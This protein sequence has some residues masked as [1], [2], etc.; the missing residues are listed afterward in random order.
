MKRTTTEHHIEES[1]D[2]A[3]FVGVK[4]TFKIWLKSL[5]LMLAFLLSAHTALFAQAFVFSGGIDNEGGTRESG[6]TVTAKG[7]AGQSVT[8]NASGRYK[9]QLEYGKRHTIEVTKSGYA[10]RFF[11]V[12]LTNVREQDLSS[13]EDFASL[14]FVMVQEAPGVDLSALSSTPITTFTFQ[15][16]AGQLVKDDKQEAASNKAVEDAKAKKSSPNQNTDAANKEN[17]NKLKE[18]IKVG[19]QAFAAGDFEKAV[20]AFEDAIDFAGKNKLDESE[21]LSKL[22][23]ADAELKKK[24]LGELE[25]RQ[26]NEALFKLIDEGKKLELKK[27]FK[28]AKAKY[29]EA[30]NKKPGYK[31]AVDLLEKVNKILAEQEAEEKKNADYQKVIAEAKALFDAE[32]WKESK[33]KYQEAKT[34][35]ATEKEPDAQILIIDKKIAE[36]EKN[37]AALAKYEGI[38]A[39]ALA[40][41]NAEKY[42][43]AIAKYKEAQLAMKDRNEP[44]EGLAFCEQKKKEKADL[45]KAKADQE[46]LDKDYTAAV[47]KADGLYDGKKYAEAIKEYEIANKLK[48]DEAHPVT[49]MAAAKTAMEDMASAEE[50]KKQFELLKKDGEKALTINKLAEAKEKFMAANSIIE[51]DAFVVQKIAEINKKEQ[52]QADALALENAYKNALEQGENAV[53]NS[54]YTEAK[55]FFEEAKKLKPSEKLP[56][57]RINFVDG[58]LKEMQADLAKKQQFDNLVAAANAKEANNDLSGALAELKKAYELIKDGGVQTRITGLEKSIAD[59]NASAQ[60]KAQYD[61]A[62]QKADLAFNKKEWENAIKL[63]QE[64]KKIDA[65]LNYADEKI[66]AAQGE[67]AKMQNA[68]QRKSSFDKMFTDA[69]KLFNEKKYTDADN[70]YQNALNY[71]DEQADKD[72][73]E[74]RRTEIKEIVDKQEAL[75]Q[76]KKAFDDAIA[77]AQNLEKAN[78]LDGALARYKEAGDLDNS[79]P[80]PKQKIGEL[81]QKIA[82]RDKN[83]AQQT[84]FNQIIAAGDDLFGA[85]KFPEAIAKYKEAEP[86]IPNSPI[87][88]QKIEEANKKI[89]EVEQNAAETAYQK[90]LGDAQN[91]RD[92]QNYDNALKLYNQAATQRPNDPLP[93]AKIKEINEEIERNKAEAA[94]TQLKKNRFNKLVEDGNKLFSAG[95][96]DKALATFN[97][98]TRL[99]P[100]EAEPKK[101]IEDIN[102]IIATRMADAE[103]Q[104]NQQAELK[105]LTDAGDKAFN[106][107]KFDEALQ[108]YKDALAL[109]PGDENLNSKIKLTEERISGLAKSEEERVWRSKL[110]A[111]DKAFT[112]RDYDL[113]EALYKEVLVLNAD[114]KRANEQLVLIERIKT[115]STEPTQLSDFGN[116]S[117]HSIIE[118]EALMAQAERQRE[119]NRL[120]NLRNQIVAMETKLDEQYAQKEL[121]VQSTLG[122]TVELEREKALSTEERK[123]EQMR[124]ENLVRD[125]VADMDNAQLLENLLAYKDITDVQIQIRLITEQ[126]VEGVQGNFRIPNMN[127][128]EMKQYLLNITQNTD[129]T[130]LNHLELLLGN[131]KFIQ[132]LQALSQTDEDFSRMLIELNVAFITAVMLNLDNVPVDQLQ[133]Q[134]DYLNKVLESLDNYAAFINEETAR[135]NTSALDAYAKVERIY[136]STRERA[137][138]DRSEHDSQRQE[139]LE[140]IKAVQGLI[141]ENNKQASNNQ[142]DFH[143]SVVNL[144]SSHL[145]VQLAMLRLNYLKMQIHDQELKA[146]MKYGTEDYD[147]W[148]NDIKNSYAELKELERKIQVSTDKINADTQTLAYRNTQ[149]IN[150]MILDKETTYSEDKSKQNQIT[151]EV[152]Q[153]ERSSA[154]SYQAKLED[155]KQQITKNRNFLDQ[156]ERREISFNESAANALGQQFPEGVT[157]ENYV[158]KDSDGLVLEVKTRRIVV[159]NGVGN[160]YVRHSNKYGVTYSKNGVSITEYQWTKETQNAKLPKYK[161]N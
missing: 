17:Q 75:A 92:I 94:N 90:L 10:K 15:K 63:Y 135:N 139:I 13:G 136:E 80:L 5:F 24:K 49:R 104:R 53:K 25:E 47:S 60:K 59:Q 95:D 146:L 73:T 71:A 152:V 158:T 68:K 9:L 131:D 97:E 48:P 114:N 70:A 30:L 7:G 111:A 134:Q 150:Q 127:D 101:R 18:K 8:T 156:L 143:Q 20:K 6:V 64:A 14:D 69:E 132:G 16:K 40:F 50:K 154:D 124:T 37:A 28:G 113:A 83:N 148:V 159:I 87:A 38:M 141:F 81:N 119:Y 140:Q 56:Q 77:T 27:D 129:A 22:D 99:F 65:T 155:A 157:E 151:S 145:D 61:A 23:K 105:R 78:D 96:L 26:A 55:T 138:N 43:E 116:P 115:P 153:I 123:V 106:S 133:K 118:G 125:M 34:I 3:S 12:D 1:N 46:K 103:T 147:L 41:Q 33:A 76:K 107:S 51:G 120:K 160:V 45:A 110:A 85:G 21:A 11:I 109:K 72:K 98:A 144:Q 31:D 52:E 39:A 79:A 108:N 91:A 122:H 29:E 88:K 149:D 126:Y 117:Y 66:D 102:N 2:S 161:V 84:K 82:E 89:K 58:K 32:Q 142:T 19:D 128:E 130:N 137:E 112:D 86:L 44:S 54:A 4:N 35:K 121:D 42:D 93:K 62:I 36:Q 67:L 74:K 100:E 57:D